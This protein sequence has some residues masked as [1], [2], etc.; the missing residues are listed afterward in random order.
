K[1]ARL[2]TLPLALAS[3]IMGSFL[4]AYVSGFRWSVFGLAVL[5]TLLLQVLSNFANDYG[6]SVHGADSADRQGP[7]RAVSSG[8]IT[9]RQMKGA[10]ALF[11]LAAF[12]SGIALLWV[13]LGANQ[14]VFFIFLGLGIASI[15][16]AITYT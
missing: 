1:A 12:A 16:A 15:L 10:V 5:T 9:A 8:Q 3:I 7:D 2:R 13:A 11:A 4:A 14:S 6:D